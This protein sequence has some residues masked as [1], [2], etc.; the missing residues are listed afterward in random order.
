L[1]RRA[2][3]LARALLC[4]ACVSLST[5]C[6]KSRLQEA[7]RQY[8]ALMAEEQSDDMRI[9]ALARFV[10]GRPDKK[11][12]PDIT[13]ACMAIGRHHA[14]AGRPEQAAAWFERALATLPDEP[15][16]LNLVGYHYATQGTA[17]DRSIA[18]LSRGI[19]IARARNA[20]PNQLA[21][22]LHSLG[23]AYRARGDLRGALFLLSEARDLAPE[24][25]IIAE[26]LAQVRGEIEARGESADA[27]VS[28]TEGSAAA[29]RGELDVGGDLQPPVEDGDAPDVEAGTQGA[30]IEIP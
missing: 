17:L 11:T 26:H 29:G 27:T 18:L 5:G 30:G 10:E 21:R 3:P 14:R 20:P 13:H 6:E 16:L 15:I 23:W 25:A 24:V 9:A 12:N 22:M 1:T 2:A 4:V 7:R 8:R 28:G 19:A